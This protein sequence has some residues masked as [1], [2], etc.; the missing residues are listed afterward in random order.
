MTTLQRVAG[1]PAPI[2]ATFDISPVNPTLRLYADSNRTMLAASVTMTST[3][4]P[5]AFQAALPVS[6]PA[7]TYFLQF[8]ADGQPPD[9]DDTLVLLAPGVSVGTAPAWS[10]APDQVASRISQRT[11]ERGGQNRGRPLGAFTDTTVPTSTQVQALCDVAAREVLGACGEVP[12]SLQ[13]QASDVAADGAA[14]RVELQFYRDDSTG[15]YDDL[16][17][18][19]E[20]SLKRLRYAVKDLADGSADGG[21]GTRAY[22]VGGI[23]AAATGFGGGNPYGRYGGYST[24]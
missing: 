5:F 17:A 11:V 2:V 16:L 7:G 15:T 9:S 18:L 4:N 19:Y 3:A 14:A 8:T 13:A 22:S 20:A 6:L 10:P 1:A 24:W 12:A 21:L 23:P